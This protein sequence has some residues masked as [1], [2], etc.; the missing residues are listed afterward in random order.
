MHYTQSD[1]KIIYT[2]E[3]NIPDGI[4]RKQSFPRWNEAV[5]KLAQAYENQII[6]KK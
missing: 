4:I 1:N 2:K 5:K 6:L 3:L